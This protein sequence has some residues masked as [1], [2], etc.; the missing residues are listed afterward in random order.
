M[1]TQVS[2]L[3]I[4]PAVP[5]DAD[6]IAAYMHRLY[7]EPHN[8]VSH[9]PG[10]GA[11]TVEE[12]LAYIAR[13]NTT[14]DSGIYVVA[15]IGNAIVGDA[16]WTRG[17]R[18]TN[19]H[20]ATMGFSVDAAWRRRGIATALMHYMM[21]WAR[22]HALVR[23]ELKVF[24]RNTAAIALYQK[25]GFRE[26]GRHPYAFCKQGIWVNDLTMALVLPPT[27]ASPST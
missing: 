4:R 25:F 13:L 18:L 9:D 7:S 6:A 27:P 24:S 8:N 16:R 17:S 2:D 14:P 3:R 11:I 12:T 20:A 10:Q 22:E 23:L 15:T 1:T 5:E 19:R 26:E 21:A